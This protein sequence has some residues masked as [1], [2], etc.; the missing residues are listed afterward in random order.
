M[1]TLS[2]F[3]LW[4]VG[5]A[6]ARTY[7]TAAECDCLARHAAGR[8]RLVE[9]GCW[10]GVNTARLRGVMAPDGVLFG[11][12]PYR[13]GRLGFSAQRIIAHHEV[14]RVPNGT[15]RW[16]RTTDVEAARQFAAAGEPQ[17][18]FVFSD[19]LNTFEGFGRTW[20]AWSP[21]L[22]PGG[23]YI[24]ANSRSSPARNLESA[25]SARYTRDV[26]RRDPRFRVLE[27]IDTFTVLRAVL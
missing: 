13:P 25:G 19:S 22:A 8:K 27:E 20:E 2:H 26:I 1:T 6:K 16:M 15:M 4:S 5:L 18:D 3:V 24:L 21:L 9:I 14:G 17:V 12:D 10:H 7:Y 23:I 11:I